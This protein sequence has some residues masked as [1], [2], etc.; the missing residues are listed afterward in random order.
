[1]IT[2]EYF[3]EGKHI[4]FKQQLPKNREHILKDI[5]AFSNTSGG[6]LILGIEDETGVVVGIGDQSPFKLSIM[7]HL[8]KYLP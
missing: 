4:E 5:I 3:G 8:R 6:K 1:M 2:K 7:E